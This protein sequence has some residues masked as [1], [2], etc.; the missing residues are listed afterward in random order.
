M[1]VLGEVEFAGTAYPLLM[2]RM[3]RGPVPACVSA[4][5]HGDEPAG[6]E[7][8]VKLLDG[9]GPPSG[10][11]ERF[12]LTVYPCDNPSGYELR[13]RSNARGVDLNREFRKDDASPEVALLMRSLVP[14]DFRLVY[15]MHEDV[16]SPGL[17]LYE[18]AEDQHKEVGPEIVRAAEEIGIPIN[19]ASEIEGMPA[20]GGVINRRSVNRPMPMTNLPKAL[21]LYQSCADHVITM[22]PPASVVPMEKRVAILLKGLEIALRS[23]V[24]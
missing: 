2:L 21:Y 14:C 16:D 18:L 17:Y 4:G 10:L 8:V 6:V 12:T 22:E 11:L 3:G 13:T 23:E 15:E 20:R 24:D 7:A 19:L 9:E 5:I 1:E